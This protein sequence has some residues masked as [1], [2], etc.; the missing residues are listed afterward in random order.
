MNLNRRGIKRHPCKLHMRLVVNRLKVQTLGSEW[1]LSAIATCLEGCQGCQ[2]T[3]LL[4]SCSCCLQEGGT[5]REVGQRGATAALHVAAG[6]AHAAMQSQQQL[7][8]VAGIVLP[9]TVQLRLSLV[10]QMHAL[11]TALVAPLSQERSMLCGT[12]VQKAQH[13]QALVLARVQLTLLGSLP[14][15]PTAPITRNHSAQ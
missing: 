14:H 11:I 10:T 2:L 9:P 4:A 5:A 12:V 7:G 1:L 8:T 3:E 15:A 6:T 13:M